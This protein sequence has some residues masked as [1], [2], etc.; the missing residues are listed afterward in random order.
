MINIEDNRMKNNLAIIF[1]PIIMIGIMGFS[2]LDG[3]TIGAIMG[4]LA[5]V[6]GAGIAYI[7]FKND[8]HRRTASG[9]FFI[10][11]FFLMKDYLSPYYYAAT[12][13]SDIK[14]RYP[15]YDVIAKYYPKE[16]NDYIDLMK[17]NI[18][19]KGSLNNEINYSANLVN[20]AVQESIPFASTKSI[21]NYLKI[22]LKFEKNLYL[23]DPMLVIAIEYPGRVPSQYSLGMVSK[24]ISE[25]DIKEKMEAGKEVIESGSANKTP[26]H[27]SDEEAKE[28][29]EDIQQIISTLNEKYGKQL[30]DET[31]SSSNTPFSDPKKSAEITISL[32]EDILAKGEERG[33]LLFKILY[34]LSLEDGRKKSN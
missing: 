28:A 29:A 5:G 13:E 21:Y 14:N 11:L 17:K 15:I 8:K 10:L 7:L 20:H 18:L 24:S 33:G 23:I 32:S 4:V 9:I 6:I 27:V 3:R 22:T 16:F 2:S 34:L 25:D 12:Y 1:L 19:A 31:F 26:I 30:V